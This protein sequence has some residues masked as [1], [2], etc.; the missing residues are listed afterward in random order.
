MEAAVKSIN[1]ILAK[2]NPIGV[3]ENLSLEE[4]KRY[5]PSILNVIEDRQ[6]LINCLEDI[7]IN[8]LQIGYDPTNEN[9]LESLSQV[10]DELIR[11][12]RKTKASN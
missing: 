6:Q 7:L 8:K 12:Y 5:I 9:H 1:L 3:P 4:Y 10:C 11:A 2:W